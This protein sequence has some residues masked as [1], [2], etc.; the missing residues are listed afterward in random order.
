MDHQIG[1][2]DE[3]CSITRKHLA[4]VL[5]SSMAYLIIRIRINVNKINLPDFLFLVVFIFTKVGAKERRIRMNR[6]VKYVLII[7]F[8]DEYFH[9]WDTSNSWIPHNE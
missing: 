6:I 3:G 8:L 1:A 2:W 7:T 9:L 4:T 5:F